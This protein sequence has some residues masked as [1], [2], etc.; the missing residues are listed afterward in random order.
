MRSGGKSNKNG[1]K[2][3]D[4]APA[5]MTLDIGRHVLRARSAVPPGRGGLACYHLHLR[6][7][8]GLPASVGPAPFTLTQTGPRLEGPAGSLFSSSPV[9]EALRSKAGCLQ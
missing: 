5:D 7:H 1:G 4:K 9:S 8:A 6:S 2:T 3:N